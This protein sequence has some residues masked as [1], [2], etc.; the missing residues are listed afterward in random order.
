MLASGLCDSAN[1][2]AAFSGSYIVIRDHNR[3]FYVDNQDGD[4]RYGCLFVNKLRI[5]FFF[6]SV[7][8]FD[9]NLMHLMQQRGL[10]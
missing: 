9:G 4:R 10:K 3:I 2:R 5:D 8:A 7:I 6:Y 1:Q